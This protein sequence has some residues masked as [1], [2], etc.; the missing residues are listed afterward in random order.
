MFPLSQLLRFFIWLKD[1]LHFYFI[2]QGLKIHDGRPFPLVVL[3]Y[4]PSHFFSLINYASLEM[5]LVQL[6]LMDYI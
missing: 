5:C 6:T 4:A 1:A 3:R 2:G